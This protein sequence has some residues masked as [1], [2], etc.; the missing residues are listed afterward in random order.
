MGESNHID[1]LTTTEN[2]SF[3]LACLNVAEAEKRLLAFPQDFDCPVYHHFGPGLYIRELRVPAGIVGMGH[4]QKHPHMNNFVSGRIRLLNDDG[5]STELV[6][7]MTF[8]GMPGRKIVHVIEDM[9]W[10]NI[11]ATDETDV[12]IL[13]AT[14]LEKSEESIEH[15]SAQ[16]FMSESEIQQAREDFIAALKENDL[17]PEY[18]TEQTENT[19]DQMTMPY[20]WFKSCVLNSSIH[21]KGLFASGFFLAGEVIAPVVIDGKRTPAGRY[22]N[23][24]NQ[25]NAEGLVMPN[26]DVVLIALRNISGCKSGARGEEITTDYRKAI[27]HRKG[28]TS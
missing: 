22:T 24:S 12:E 9:V 5:S 19:A 17:T 21:G 23:H 26:G 11:Y 20:G 2:S 13:E 15:Y 14:Y 1:E 25:P 6:A 8:V 4:I 7:P 27:E 16:G 3:D 10:Q 18:V 28:I